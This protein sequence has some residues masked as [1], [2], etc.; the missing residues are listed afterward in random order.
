MTK[1]GLEDAYFHLL[2]EAASR[3]Y[4][5]FVS[6]QFRLLVPRSTLWPVHCPSHIHSD[7]EHSGCIFKDASSIPDKLTLMT[8]FCGTGHVN[9]CGGT[10]TLPTMHYTPW[11]SWSMSANLNWSQCSHV[12]LRATPDTVQGRVS[13]IQQHHEVG[14]VG[15]ISDNLSLV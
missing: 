3:K 7:S 5:R 2:I 1:I 8:D 10:R 4:L 13:I 11:I 14:R 12:Y 15:S 9:Y 6:R